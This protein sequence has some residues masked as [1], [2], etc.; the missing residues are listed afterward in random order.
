MSRATGSPP[1]RRPIALIGTVLAVVLAAGCSGPSGPSSDSPSASSSGPT[2]DA[3][4]TST[5]LAAVDL[6]AYDVARGR[7]CERVN[8]ATVGAVLGGEVLGRTELVPGDRPKGGDV[9]D[10][11]S[12]TVRTDAG[13]AAAWV[14]APPVRR[15]VARDLADA[16]RDRKGCRPVDA[17]DFG[18]PGAAAD[19]PDGVRIAGLFG[20]AWLTCTLT[21]PGVSLNDR[22]DRTGRWCVAVLEAASS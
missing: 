6:A 4:A 9:R 16:L 18:E 14:F 13:R 10:E 22:L 8:E 5:P 3:A 20:D 19:C 7:F 11:Y 17:P 2:T 1:H 21:Q 15:P 12:C